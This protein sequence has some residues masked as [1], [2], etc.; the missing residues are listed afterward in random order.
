MEIE[1]YMNCSNFNINNNNS[2]LGNYHD[3]I[4]LLPTK[5]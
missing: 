3:I 4:W 2:H 5:G 1:C